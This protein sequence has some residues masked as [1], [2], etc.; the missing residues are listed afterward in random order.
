MSGRRP[1]C[2]GSIVG[3]VAP[4][5]HPQ[6]LELH[7][8]QNERG[9]EHPEHE[10]QQENL[11]R[12]AGHFTALRIWPVPAQFIDRIDRSGNLGSYPREQPLRISPEVPALD[13]GQGG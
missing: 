10:K 4:G 2:S 9:F 1:G 12:F 3:P 11:D 5:S 8:R 7:L 6:L 13:P